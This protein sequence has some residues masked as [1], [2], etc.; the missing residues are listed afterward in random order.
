MKCVFWLLSVSCMV[1][2]ASAQT[3]WWRTFGGTDREE[4]N[5]VH[6]TADGGYI[7]A[8]WTESFGVGYQ[9]VYLIKT[10]A[11]G[12]TVWTR[13]Y[14]G[15]DFR[16]GLSGQGTTDGG[17]V[18]AGYVARQGKQYVF[19]LKIDASGDTLWT[20]TYELIG[21]E[22]GES[23]RRTDDGGYVIAGYT[24]QDNDDVH[25]VK[26]NPQGD[27]LWDRTYGGSDSEGGASVQQTTDGGYIIAGDTKSFGA[28]NHDVYL[29]KTNASGDTLWTRT[30][31]GPASDGGASVQQTSDGGYI[32]AG[33]TGSFGAGGG[34]AYV[35]K[36]TASGDT[37]WTRTYGGTA[38]DG[39]G[40]VQQTTDG[41]YIIVGTVNSFG[42]GK[43]DV[44][45]IKTDAQGD[46]LWTRTFGGPDDDGGSSVQQTTDGGLDCPRIAGHFLK[47]QVLVPH[48]QLG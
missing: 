15:T 23:V 35:I 46:T 44:Y 28:G 38:N 3:S 20:R 12:D 25:V 48:T 7:V 31:G 14:G 43:A 42:V 11:H 22:C 47:R 39:A 41:G 10:S 6:Q 36:T 21:Y 24:A 18:I 27:L 9:S 34:D 1:S 2:S 37:I 29:V 19:L 30:Y 8:G 40:A 26:T 16:R 13:M 17:C 5:S 33:S 32:I 45:L 4:G